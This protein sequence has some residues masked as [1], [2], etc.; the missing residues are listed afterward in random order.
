MG[1]HHENISRSSAYTH[2]KSPR[3]RPGDSR[4]TAPKTTMKEIMK[5]SMERAYAAPENQIDDYARLTADKGAQLAAW[6]AA[7]MHPIKAA[8]QYQNSDALKD[9]FARSEGG[10]ALTNGQFKGAMLAAG[11]EPVNSEQLN[12]TFHIRRVRV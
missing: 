6:I 9:I 5:F 12:W 11:H 2:P 3:Q 10:F 8:N 7:T 4:S 1:A